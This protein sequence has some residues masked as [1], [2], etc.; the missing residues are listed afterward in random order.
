MCLTLLKQFSLMDTF[1]RTRKEFINNFREQ[2]VQHA[3][4]IAFQQTE[5]KGFDLK[6]P[7]QFSTDS[8]QSYSTLSDLFS[9]FHLYFEILTFLTH[10]TLCF[11]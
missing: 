2:Y 11:K 1:F 6:S 3:T 8:S 7:F 10:L 5:I 4:F 9:R